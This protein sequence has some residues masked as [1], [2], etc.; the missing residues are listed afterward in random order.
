MVRRELE[1]KRIDP[2][3]NLL[4]CVWTSSMRRV[5]RTLHDLLDQYRIPR[6]EWFVLPDDVQLGLEEAFHWELDRALEEKI[7]MEI[8][9]R[10]EEYIEEQIEEYIEEQIED[11]IQSLIDEQLREEVL[12]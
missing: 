6:T 7:D 11:H 12:R 9:R 8:E 2:R 5:E 1:R 10:I 3:T 4:V